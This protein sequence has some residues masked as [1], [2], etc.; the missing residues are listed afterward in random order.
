MNIRFNMTK[1]ELTSALGACS[2][3][4]D[5]EHDKGANSDVWQ[6]D[7]ILRTIQALRAAFDARGGRTESA[8][9]NTPMPVEMHPAEFG[10]MLDAV[11]I[12]CTDLTED[13]YAEIDRAFTARCLALA[14]VNVEG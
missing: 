2:S 7:I 8:E 1:P 5:N 13:E 4:D 3:M 14:T 10:L 11:E 9:D 6:D 12:Y